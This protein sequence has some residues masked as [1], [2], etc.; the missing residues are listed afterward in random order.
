M[1]TSNESPS[2]GEIL[3]DSDSFVAITADFLDSSGLS[4]DIGELVANSCFSS[5]SPNAFLRT[6]STL[7][8]EKSHSSRKTSRMQQHILELESRLLEMD[9]ALDEEKKRVQD[10]ASSLNSTELERDDAFQKFQ[11]LSV[12]YQEMKVVKENYRVNELRF[13]EELRCEQSRRE[14]AENKFEKLREVA[15]EQLTKATD[16]ARILRDQ[17]LVQCDR[18]KVSHF[19]HQFFS[20]AFLCLCFSFVSPPIFMVIPVSK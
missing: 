1:G 19:P 13:Q 11:S 5:D 9:L 12:R 18:I 15:Q 3:N 20:S 4:P 2:R 8:T 6:A 17:L 16:D 10:L 7:S 14:D